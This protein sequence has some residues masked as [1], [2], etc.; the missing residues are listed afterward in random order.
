MP[1]YLLDTNACIAIRNT[2]RG[3]APKDPTRRAARERLIE[4]WKGLPVAEI[5]MSFVTLGELML[6]AEKHAAPTAARDQID[7]L[8]AAIPVARLPDADG[9]TL[10]R[11][12]GALRAGLERSGTMIPH[13]DLWIAAQALA[14]NM[15]VVTAD[16]SDF[17]RVPNLSLEDWT[18]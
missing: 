11:R 5:A 10:A 2:L 8:T 1:K 3:S 4:R 15:T 7:K 6:W 16:T 14:A 13:N 9:G 18:A 17:A 12:Y